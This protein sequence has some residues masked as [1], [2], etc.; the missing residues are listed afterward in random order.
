MFEVIIVIGCICSGKTTYMSKCPDAYRKVD[1]GDIVRSITKTT[2]R[3]HIQ[4]LDSLI[5]EELERE[6]HR[7]ASERMKGIVIVGMR[8]LSIYLSVATYCKELCFNLQRVYLS[9]PLKTL[10]QRYIKRA[11]QKDVCSFEEAMMKDIKIGYLEL[12]EHWL[13]NP[14]PIHIEKNHTNEEYFI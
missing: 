8:Q 1:V 14:L 4:D 2:Q 10:K 13:T 9:V 6:I 7:A 5:I 12:I 3:T 11:D